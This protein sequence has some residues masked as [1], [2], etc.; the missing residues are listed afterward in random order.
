MSMV[1]TDVSYQKPLSAN[2]M[3]DNASGTTKKKI[4][5]SWSSRCLVDRILGIETHWRREA[6]RRLC[7][8]ILWKP[9]SLEN[10]EGLVTQDLPSSP[11][12]TI[13]AHA[14]FEVSTNFCL[15]VKTFGLTLFFSVV[16]NTRSI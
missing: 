7:R 11:I 16:I 5:P 15:S 6:F 9:T 8:H 14:A 1:L 13:V 12:L 2:I 4:V 10:V 3:L